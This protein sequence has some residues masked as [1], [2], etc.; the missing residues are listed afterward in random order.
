M[1]DEERKRSLKESIKKN[2]NELCCSF[3]IHLI[4]ENILRIDTTV[5]VQCKN[6]RNLKRIRTQ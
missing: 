1:K 5:I 4:R 6:K 3:G 2:N